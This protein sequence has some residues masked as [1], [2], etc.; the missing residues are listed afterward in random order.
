MTPVFQQ[1]VVTQEEFVEMNWVFEG[2]R[3]VDLT[4]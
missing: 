2:K 3:S 4:I 1:S